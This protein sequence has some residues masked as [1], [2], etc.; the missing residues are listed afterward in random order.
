MIGKITLTALLPLCV[1]AA[2]SMNIEDYFK[3][4][5]QAELVYAE[6]SR[7][8]PAVLKSARE[9]YR[10][11]LFN[12]ILSMLELPAQSKTDAAEIAAFFN[13]EQ[14]SIFAAVSEYKRAMFISRT[15]YKWRDGKPEHGVWT[16]LSDQP[17]D[18]KKFIDRTPA[19]AGLAL[20][21]RVNGGRFFKAAK[22][23]PAFNRLLSKDPRLEEL[24]FNMPDNG[25][26]YFSLAIA[27]GKA[28][29]TTELPLDF[30]KLTAML[31]AEHRTQTADGTIR[32]EDD[33]VAVELK[34]VPG[35]VLANLCAG[36]VKA[37]FAARAALPTLA[38]DREFNRMLRHIEQTQAPNSISY[39]SP[40]FST[41]VLALNSQT[42]P[43]GVLALYKV[44]ERYGGTLALGYCEADGQ[45]ATAV[46]RQD[47]ALQMLELEAL[48]P[49]VIPIATVLP[50]IKD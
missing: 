32:F 9:L 16:I 30:D 48:I 19:G 31:P 50:F 28:F 7:F 24:L 42:P 4:D 46:A 34:A 26:C 38:A 27:D 11:A 29:I 13:F 10:P 20:I 49:V 5:P 25:E 17:V 22:A 14:S 47:I 36:D 39:V 45:R 2:D 37:D 43:P 18:M 23:V 40:D 21:C 15:F 3:L 8:D 35:G 44:L 41:Q 1:F 12:G 6:I 33:P